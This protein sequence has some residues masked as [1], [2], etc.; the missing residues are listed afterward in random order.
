MGVPSRLSRGLPAGAR[1]VVVRR[2]LAAMPRWRGA[3]PGLWGVVAGLL[4]RVPG[5]WGAIPR[6][7]GRGLWWWAAV[8]RLLAPIPGLGGAV[9]GLLAAV[10]GLLGAI[11]ARSRLARLRGLTVGARVTRLR[12]PPRIAP[13]ARLRGL[14]GGGRLI[15][16]HRLGLLTAVEWVLYVIRPRL[17]ALRCA[18]GLLPL[19]DNSLSFQSRGQRRGTAIPRSGCLS[20]CNHRTV[21]PNFPRGT[22]PGTWGRVIARPLSRPRGTSRS[23]RRRRR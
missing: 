2:L 9:P 18:H 6:L 5:L 15:A 22:S 12:R 20:V 23:R 7:W 13:L 4:G 17:G 14:I 11:G 21:R 8:P 3:V 1:A 10:P 16:R 19:R